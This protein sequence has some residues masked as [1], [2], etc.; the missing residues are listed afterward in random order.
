[1]YVILVN[2]VVDKKSTFKKMEGLGGW[3]AQRVA[4]TK[5]GIQAKDCWKR[6]IE[7]YWCKSFCICTPINNSNFFKI[8]YLHNMLL[9]WTGSSSKDFAT[10]TIILKLYVLIK[11]HEQWFSYMYTYLL[12][13]LCR[14]FGNTYFL[15]FTSANCKIDQQ[16][17]VVNNITY[18]HKSSSKFS[19]VSGIH[20]RT[21]V[22]YCAGLVKAINHSRNLAGPRFEPGYLKR[23]HR[24]SIH[25]ST[26]P[27]FFNCVKNPT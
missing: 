8:F 9:P 13:T 4:G 16:Y 26:T 14:V 12:S 21:S 7:W 20:L 19:E 6:S 15:P 2:R 24:S 25:Y 5:Y 17:V 1:M 11:E 18:M 10:K 27:Y 22:E 23:T 3:E